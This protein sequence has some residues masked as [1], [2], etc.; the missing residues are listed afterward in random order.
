MV[1]N[2]E[3]RCHAISNLEDL[4]EGLEG[5]VLL[6]DLRLDFRK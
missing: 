1:A 4:G 2:I 6:E 3:N 5:L